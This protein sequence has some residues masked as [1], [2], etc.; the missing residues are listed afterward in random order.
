[1][2]SG[3]L[4]LVCSLPAYS[5]V[6]GFAKA[7]LPA[8]CMSS[9]L[10]H[11]KHELESPLQA[12]FAPTRPRSPPLRRCPDCSSLHPHPA[13]DALFTIIRTLVPI[14]TVAGIRTGASRDLWA[15]CRLFVVAVGVCGGRFLLCLLHHLGGWWFFV[16]NRLVVGRVLS[17]PS[18]GWFTPWQVADV[19]DV[20]QRQREIQRAEAQEQP[21]ADLEDSPDNDFPVALV[22]RYAAQRETFRS[23]FFIFLHHILQ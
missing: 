4:L 12:F 23:F 19:W 2:I 11:N 9:F 22:R 1:M 15:A 16:S 21:D 10:Q 8:C 6:A 13:R 18:T 17:R 3:S 14:N 20:L 5:T 7:C